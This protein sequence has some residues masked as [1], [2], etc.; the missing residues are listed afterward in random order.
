MRAGAD[1]AKDFVPLHDF[2]CECNFSGLNCFLQCLH[3]YINQKLP[4]LAYAYMHLTL[5][6]IGQTTER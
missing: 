4:N 3:I 1:F 5:I 2:M 6:Y